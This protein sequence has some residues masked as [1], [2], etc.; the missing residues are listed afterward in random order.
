MTADIIATNS[1]FPSAL[2]R[3]LGGPIVVSGMPVEELEV[4]DSCLRRSGERWSALLRVLETAL[5]VVQ[6]WNRRRV[7]AVEQGQVVAG[8]VSEHYRA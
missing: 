1:R 3:R 6:G 8:V 7:L 5:E 4:V 2:E